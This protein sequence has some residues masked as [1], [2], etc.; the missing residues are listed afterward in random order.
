MKWLVSA[1]CAMVVAA[2][3]VA[4]AYNTG[5]FDDDLTK[6]CEEALRQRLKAP[7]QYKRIRMARDSK[8]MTRD[9]FITH[10]NTSGD[11]ESVRRFY[12]KSFD[13]KEIEPK[14][15]SLA[16]EYDAPNSFGT[17]LRGYADCTYGSTY[18]RDPVSYLFVK[19]DGKTS[20]EWLQ[21]SSQ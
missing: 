9:E 13:A 6:S 21:S 2:G 4:F 7:S 3:G 15:L 11:T 20:T 5:Y 12:L 19:I 17:M 8:D 10:L 16:I 18:G 1:A 14:N